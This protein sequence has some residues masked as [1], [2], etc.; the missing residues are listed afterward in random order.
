LVVSGNPW[1]E[2]NFPETDLTYVH[3]GQPVTIRI[4][5]YPDAHGW[6][7]VPWTA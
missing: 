2:A 4:D 5:T 7:G 6:K 3:P 1:I